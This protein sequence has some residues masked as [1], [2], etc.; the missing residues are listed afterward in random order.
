MTD[1]RDASPETD[2][3]GAAD[4]ARAD[5]AAGRRVLELEGRA[6]SALARALDQ[7][8]AGAVTLLAAATGRVIVTGMGKSG[9]VGRKIAATLASTGTPAQYVH[10][11]E[12]SHGDMGM[13]TAADA[14]LAISNS[15]ETR[16][17]GDILQYA[18]RFSIPVV[19]ITGDPAATLAREATIAL[20]LPAQPE[21][22][23]IGLAPT[24]STTMTLA[25]GDAIAVALLERK[26]FSASDFRILH[27]GGKLGRQL[28]RVRDLMHVGGE[29][30]LTGG[31][32]PM[33]EAILVM[34]AKR[35]GC[36]GVIDDTGRLEGIVTDGDLRRH[37]SAELLQRP[38]REIMTRTPVTVEPNLL[39]VEAL[40]R[41]QTAKIS[42]I[43]VVAEGRPAGI[44]HLHDFLRAGVA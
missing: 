6:V 25:L 30:P 23:A 5:I 3:Q 32:P 41:M 26:G 34:A 15:G 35:F 29:M 19:A 36:I 12:A 2:A 43:F 4:Q 33:H 22:G 21:A 13:V 31:N 27:P 42:V 16:E 28:V 38:V 9:H 7:T 24:T 1:R 18:R 37:M 44:V 14:I 39:A 10:P 40:A 8:F 11:A 20:I 17:L